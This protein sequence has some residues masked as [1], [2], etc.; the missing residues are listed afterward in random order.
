[1]Q[2]PAG[3]PHGKALICLVRAESVAD[4]RYGIGTSAAKLCP[5]INIVPEAG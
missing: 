3:L 1:M 2:R 4:N 5:G